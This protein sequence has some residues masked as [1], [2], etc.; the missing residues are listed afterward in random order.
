MNDTSTN[1]FSTEELKLITDTLAER[2]GKPIDTERADIELR[3]YEGDRELKKS[4]SE[5]TT[6]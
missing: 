4:E 1:D 3:V 2:F 5:E 6:S